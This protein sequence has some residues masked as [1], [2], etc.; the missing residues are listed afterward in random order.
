MGEGKRD[1]LGA[2]AGAEGEESIWALLVTNRRRGGK[3]VGEGTAKVS[4]YLLVP[5]YR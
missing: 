2:K 1:N 5:D 3:E 4:V